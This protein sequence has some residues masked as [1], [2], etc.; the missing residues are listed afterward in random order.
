MNPRLGL[1]L[2]KLVMPF[3]APLNDACVVVFHHSHVE[4]LTNP[5]VC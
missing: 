1:K 4:T 2:R 5:G 3:F